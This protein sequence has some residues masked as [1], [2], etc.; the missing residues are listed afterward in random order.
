MRP[1]MSAAP[2]YAAPIFAMPPDGG[3]RF[4]L[5]FLRGFAPDPTGASPRT[6]PKELSSFGILQYEAFFV[7]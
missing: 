3:I 1:A 5:N 2:P 7:G 6:P 4:D